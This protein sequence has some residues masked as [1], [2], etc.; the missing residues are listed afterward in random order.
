MAGRQEFADAR[1][2]SSTPMN[3]DVRLRQEDF[4]LTDRVIGILTEMRKRDA[5]RED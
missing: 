5:V 1:V 4:A 3:S 2:R